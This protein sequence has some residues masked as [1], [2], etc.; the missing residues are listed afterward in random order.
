MTTPGWALRNKG[1]S[2]VLTLQRG[3]NTVVDLRTTAS[4]QLVVTKTFTAGSHATWLEEGQ[5]IPT[6]VK[7]LKS[8][9][10]HDNIVDLL[11]EIPN[12]PSPGDFTF[13]LQF[14]NGGD[15]SHLRKHMNSLGKSCYIPE[16]WLWSIF[17][18]LVRA[19]D[20][21]HNHGI[22]HG[23]F[24]L[25]QW[26]F[27]FHNSNIGA[28]FPDVVLTDFEHANPQKDDINRLGIFLSALMR[29]YGQ[30]PH[31][32]T[33]TLRKWVNHCYVSPEG[34]PTA[35]ELS[36]DMIPVAEDILDRAQ[37][38]VLP[39]WAID[40]FTNHRAKIAEAVERVLADP[41]DEE[42]IWQSFNAP[43]VPQA[44]VLFDATYENESDDSFV[45]QLEIR[46][47]LDVSSSYTQRFGDAGAAQVRDVLEDK[48]IYIRGKVED[49]L[50]SLL[51]GSK[52]DIPEETRGVRTKN[53]DIWLTRLGRML[54][55]ATALDW[56]SFEEQVAKFE[57]KHGR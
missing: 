39:R 38:R 49:E 21:T 44:P 10:P 2:L 32:W 53:L 45:C 19:L 14:Y 3:G 54:G 51:S 47:N 7:V 52:A 24:H 12:V 11:T 37:N 27:H 57:A 29:D 36:R 4:R 56:S 55:G 35:R 50:F 26:L 13:V 18:D 28:G 17:I 33:S 46:Y 30:P 22:Y 9:P 41:R 23:D 16:T 42:A 40:Y 8:I 6:E 1:Y 5:Q 15:A 25:G 43:H 31:G 20:H 48:L 34:V